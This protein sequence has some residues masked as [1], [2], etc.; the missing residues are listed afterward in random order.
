MSQ[1][2]RVERNEPLLAE[3]LRVRISELCKRLIAHGVLAISA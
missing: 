3:G 1:R 2:F